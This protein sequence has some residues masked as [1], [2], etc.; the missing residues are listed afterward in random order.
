MTL[1]PRIGD[2]R[3]SARRFK[4][5]S[6]GDA[7]SDV[8]I[9]ARELEVTLQSGRLR[10]SSARDS[11]RAISNCRCLRMMS[12]DEGEGAFIIEDRTT[13]NRACENMRFSR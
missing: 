1:A 9:D 2:A 13:E 11:S 8:L 12:G 3:K 6:E 7:G 4:T 5:A 10:H